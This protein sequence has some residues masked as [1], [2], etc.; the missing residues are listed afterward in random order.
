MAVLKYGNPRL[1]WSGRAMINHFKVWLRSS[2][3]LFKNID[4]CSLLDLRIVL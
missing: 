4:V 2:R 3:D 1:I